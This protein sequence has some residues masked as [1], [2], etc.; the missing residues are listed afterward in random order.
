M[1]YFDKL[2]ESEQTNKKEIETV[3]SVPVDDRSYLNKFDTK[4]FERRTK[5]KKKKEIIINKN[6]DLIPLIGEVL[7]IAN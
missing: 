1:L 7:A 6:F 2:I 5:I 4:Y 3:V